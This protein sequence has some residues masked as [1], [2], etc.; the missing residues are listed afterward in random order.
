MLYPLFFLAIFTH[1]TGCFVRDSVLPDW[2]RTFPFYSTEH[3]LGYQSWRF[4]IW[5]FVL[6]FFERVYREVRYRQETKIVAV[7]LHP[8]NCLEVR[9]TKPSL[10]YKAGMWLFLNCPDVSYW[11]AH[12]FTISSAPDDPFI[13][14]HIRLVG[15]WTLAFAERLGLSEEVRER[16]LRTA[17]KQVEGGDELRPIDLDRVAL[18]R[19][20][21]ILRV[22]G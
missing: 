17:D 18:G 8:S 7:F 10:T 6:Y 9:F 3:C 20:L 2:T 4:T 14:C 13:S 21:P 11:Q 19:P 12:P 1:A 16:S 5:P 22:D 15:D